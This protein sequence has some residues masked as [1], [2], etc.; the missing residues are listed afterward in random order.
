MATKKVA[1]TKPNYRKLHE[2]TDGIAARF[3]TAQ[4]VVDVVLQHLLD[5]NGED[6]NAELASTLGL[7]RDHMNDAH[8]D[9]DRLSGELA[10]ASTAEAQS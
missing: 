9:L 2:R 4:S 5:H 7:A 6:L 1:P 3:L 10:R 8:D